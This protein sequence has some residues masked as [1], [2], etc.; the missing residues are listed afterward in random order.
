LWDLEEYHAPAVLYEP[1]LQDLD[2]TLDIIIAIRPKQVKCQDEAYLLAQFP[3]GVS[4]SL[5]SN[6]LGAMTHHSKGNN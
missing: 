3:A 2:D 5:V 4:A 1:Q 6:R